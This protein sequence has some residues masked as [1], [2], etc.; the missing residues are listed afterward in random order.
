MAKNRRQNP[1]TARDLNKLFFSPEPKKPKKN[2]FAGL[3]HGGFKTK[4]EAITYYYN[5]INKT[6]EQKTPESQSP[7]K[8]I[9]P[10]ISKK[11]IEKTLK[12]IKKGKTG[13]S[14][15]TAFR[16][17]EKKLDQLK[18]DHKNIKQIKSSISQAEHLKLRQ[19][20]IFSSKFADNPIFRQNYN[21]ILK[22]SRLA[23]QNGY[24]ILKN[25]KIFT[26]SA[27]RKYTIKQITNLTKDFVTKTQN[28]IIDFDPDYLKYLSNSKNLKKLI[29]VVS[30]RFLN[31]NFELGK[32]G[33]DLSS[34]DF[35]QSKKKLREQID[36]YQATYF[37]KT[38]MKGYRNTKFFR[39]KIEFVGSDEIEVKGIKIK[40]EISLAVIQRE[41]IISVKNLFVNRFYNDLLPYDG[42][43]EA[44]ES[45][46]NNNYERGREK[47]ENFDEI[48]VDLEEIAKTIKKLFEKKKIG[49]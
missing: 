42:L 43:Y 28:L 5:K 22:I 29:D 32:F 26:D 13:Y 35:R 20:A 6:L 12:G 45:V 23:E 14:R 33:I 47:L 18:L 48:R 41:A 44:L 3:K 19:K 38:G 39:L 37:D 8:K 16:R 9:K 27:G 31:E 24:E 30:E 34:L 1:I 2:N 15:T 7:K 10:L 36:Q 25:A 21:A 49:D 4:K 46:Y 17:L 11:E 40:N